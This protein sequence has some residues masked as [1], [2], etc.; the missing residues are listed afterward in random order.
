MNV[1]VNTMSSKMLRPAGAI[2]RDG[3]GVESALGLDRY[4][5]AIRFFPSQ[6]SSYEYEH[7]CQCFHMR[8][9]EDLVLT[10]RSR[11]QFAVHH[12]YGSPSNAVNL[13]HLRLQCQLILVDE[14]QTLSKI[15]TNQ[16][17]SFW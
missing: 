13:L 17:I 16:I 5:R 7:T 15:L 10:R 1:Y 14:M 4:E 9:D 6:D 11:I 3:Q 2:S 12:S 8:R